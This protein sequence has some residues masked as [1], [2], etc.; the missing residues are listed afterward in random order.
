MLIIYI[1]LVFVLQ[2]GYLLYDRVV[3]PA[4]VGVIQAVEN[5]AEDS[6]VDKGSRA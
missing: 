4:E 2:S 5:A 6:T 1:F 3:R